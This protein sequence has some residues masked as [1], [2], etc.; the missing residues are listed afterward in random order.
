MTTSPDRM[1]SLKIVS[2]IDWKVLGELVSPK[3]MTVGSK[4]PLFVLKAAFHSSP[5]LIHM[6]LNPFLT[7]TFEKSR[8]FAT[9]S[10][11]SDIRGSGWLFITV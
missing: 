2:I 9:R 4:S 5:S 3:N 11:S 7:S 10:M 8:A 1:R 6:L